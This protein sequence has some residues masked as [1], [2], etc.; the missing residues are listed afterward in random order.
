MSNRIERIVLAG[1]GTAGH[2]NPLLSVAKA[3]ETMDGRVQICVIGTAQG[4]ETRL[5]PAAGFELD[6]IDKLPFPR[7]LNMDALRFPFRW[8]TQSRRVRDILERHQPQVVVG[9]GGYVAAPV[10]VQAHR[11]GLPIVIHEQNARA[12]MANKLGARWARLIA[13]TYDNTGLKPRNGATMRTIGLPLRPPIARL[14]DELH[15][16]RQETRVSCA[17]QLGLDPSRSILVVTGG[18]LG[19]VSLNNALAGASAALLDHT[20]VVHLTGRGRDDEVRRTVAERAGAAALNDLDPAHVGQGDY[21]VSPYLERIDLAFGCADLVVCRAG[22]GTVAELAALGLPAVYVPLP[23]GN[24]EQ[25]YNVQPLID[26]GGG[27]VVDDHE[28]TQAWVERHIVELIDDEQRLAQLGAR[29][30]SYGIRD[31]AQVLATCIFKMG[32]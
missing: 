1:G 3:L 2:V 16:H 8:V 18:S 28:F 14:C 32:E 21:H 11:L 24:G 5:V 25:R 23:I 29:A 31:A 6:T 17:R 19:A 22:A 9:F 10:Y 15:E 27:V 20:Q 4:L 30:W 7:S 26:A 13:T 12:G